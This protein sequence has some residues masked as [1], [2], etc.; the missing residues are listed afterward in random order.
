M[1]FKKTSLILISIILL[2]SMSACNDNRSTSTISG[3]I[4][5]L[6][7]GGSEDNQIQYVF[8]KSYL[9]EE[10]YKAIIGFSISEKTNFF[11]SNGETISVDELEKGMDIEITYYGADTDAFSAEAK[12]IKILD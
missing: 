9:E 5:N 6:G 4:N 2:I 7:T 8:L 11:N 3:E 1:K 12:E 10:G